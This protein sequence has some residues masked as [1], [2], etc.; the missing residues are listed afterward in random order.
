MIEQS[1][2][3][4]ALVPPETAVTVIDLS[5]LESATSA[6][7]KSPRRRIIQPLHKD[8]SNRLQ[9]MINAVQ[10]GSYIRP[11]RHAV[12]RGESIV[13]LSGGLLY[14]V[15]DDHGRVKQHFKVQA[16]TSC[17]GIDVDGGIWH[18]FIVLERD[19]VLFEVKPGPYDSVFDKEFAL[20]A[21]EEYSPEVEAY[22]EELLQNL[23]T[24]R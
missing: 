4:M 12:E 13:V 22:I 16:G 14:L 19:T 6:S 5:L 11:H 2:Y 8:G 20:W 23:T 1:D 9:R 21:P 15:F 18:S 17:F 7:R 10:P 3:P 24:S